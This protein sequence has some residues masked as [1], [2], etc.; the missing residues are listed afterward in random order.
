M[1]TIKDVAREAGV[2]ISTVSNVSPFRDVPYTSW[3]AA[4]IKTAVQNGWVSG[5]I[6]GTFRPGNAIKLEE[7][8]SAVLKLLGY[9]A[10]D[11]TGT[12]PYAQLA[13]YRTLGLSK[14]IAAEQGEILTRGDC[15]TLF[16]NALNAE[17]KEGKIYAETLGY[18]VN[19]E[20]EID[21]AKLITATLKGPIIVD[22]DS[23]QD[24]IPFSVSDAVV[25][26]NGYISSSDQITK[27]DVIYY[28]A[29]LKKIWSYSNKVSGMYESA[30]PNA[31]SP[32]T[33][34]VSGSAYT[35]SSQDAAYDLS[36]LGD[37]RIGDYITLLLGMDGG[38]AGVVSSDA[39]S[40]TVYGV[41][42]DIGKKEYK[43][44]EGNAYT[45][46]SVS[47]KDTEGKQHTYS[48]AASA[49]TKG[50]VVQA[51]TSGGNTVI[52]LLPVK[53]VSGSVNDAGTSAA[54]YAFASDIHIL[55]ISG[56]GTTAINPKRLAGAELGSGNVRYFTLNINNEITDMIL[57]DMTWDMYKYGI[58]LTADEKIAGMSISSSYMCDFGG[59]QTTLSSSNTAFGVA[60]GPC[61]AITS[62]NSLVR[63]KNL[64]AAEIESIG[65][66]DTQTSAGYSKIWDNV[67]VY[68]YKDSAYYLTSL[69][70]ISDLDEYNLTGY[71]DRSTSEGG[72][73]RVIIAVKK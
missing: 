40:K 28:S 34:T 24:E 63:I 26:R 72:R 49:L 67:L 41:I 36:T 52:N 55:D 4:Y 19:S 15:M 39:C 48:T 9:A 51:Y 12:Y 23:W 61:Y 8:V 16:Y 47:I 25:F 33:V 38:V 73:I 2:A 46:M 66:T 44:A 14:D 18:S 50:D 21:Y 1:V 20:N 42:T 13:M 29:G 27:Y 30:A 56:A 11:F 37:F 62:G 22:D 10:S 7:A 6:D 71:Y 45:A 32:S 53:Y 54:G 17:S 59:M 65:L 68:E 31:L 64:T 69:S 58:I 57:N 60:K 70:L 3:A 43:D 35:I 5:Y